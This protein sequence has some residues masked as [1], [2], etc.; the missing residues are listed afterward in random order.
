MQLSQKGK[1]I[2]NVFFAFSEF[3]LNFQHFQKKKDYTHN[4][5][6]LGVTDSQRGG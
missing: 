4:G 1:M 5:C 3:R 2:C 6:I